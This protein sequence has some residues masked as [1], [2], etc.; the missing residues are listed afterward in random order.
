MWVIENPATGLLKTR[1]FMERLPWV[2]VTYCKYG[3]PY[4]KQTRLW[5]NM[6]WRPRR[7]LCRPGSRCE[8]WQDGRHLRA[9][10]RGPRLMEGQYERVSRSRA[11]LQRSCCA[12]RGD[13]ARGHGGACGAA[14]HS[15]L[16]F[17]QGAWKMPIFHV[18]CMFWG[19][20]T[21]HQKWR[22]GAPPAFFLVFWARSKSGV[23]KHQKWR[24]GTPGLF[25]PFLRRIQKRCHSASKMKQS[26]TGPF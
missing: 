13:C 23:T 26:G 21:K 5:T 18:F 1:P 8:A 14:E 4:R 10:Q 11:A 7:S 16:G 17:L 12:V 15:G 25:L 22:R 20:A 19:G 6:R 2:D 9:A 3:T 24:R